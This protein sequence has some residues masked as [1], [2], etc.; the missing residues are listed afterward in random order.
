M[1]R[2]TLFYFLI[3]QIVLIGLCFGQTDNLSSKLHE[4]FCKAV[5]AFPSDSASLC[6]FYFERFIVKDSV[7][8]Y[9]SKLIGLRHYLR[10]IPWIDTMI[11]KKTKALLIEIVRMESISVSQARFFV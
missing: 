10:L 9:K 11:L 4:V 7:L 1:K 5:K 6:A 2:L 8:E 3:S